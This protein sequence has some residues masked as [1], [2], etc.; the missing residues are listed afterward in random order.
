MN[1]RGTVSAVVLLLTSIFSAPSFSEEADPLANF[2]PEVN[3]LRAKVTVVKPVQKGQPIE[4]QY[5]KR[6]VSKVDLTIW[7][8]GFWPN[9]QIIVKDFAGKEAA[10]TDFG[11]QVRAA[12]NPGGPRDKNF[13]MNLKPNEED[14][15][16][17]AYDLNRLFNLSMHGKYTVQV[18]YEEKQGG[19][20][21]RL[22]SNI[23]DFKILDAAAK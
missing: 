9:H 12:F 7:H 2:G 6:N 18:I 13:S 3:G 16:Q 1:R 14:N 5:S 19:W 8:S 20:E 17:G 23:A 15:S 22:P 4:I 21:G 11:K 10:L